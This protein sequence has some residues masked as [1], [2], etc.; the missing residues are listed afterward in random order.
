[1]SYSHIYLL[2]NHKENVKG[3][4]L[5]YMINPVYWRQDLCEVSKEKERKVFADLM[6]K[7]Q[8]CIN[9]ILESAKK[10]GAEVHLPESC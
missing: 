7:T 10:D 4:K 5:V 2:I 6:L 3:L 1:M 9:A 8:I